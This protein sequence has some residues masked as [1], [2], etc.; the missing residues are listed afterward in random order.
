MPSTKSPKLSQEP[1]SGWCA[2]YSGQT[3]LG[4]LLSRGRAGA[5]AFDRNDRSLGVFPDLKSAAAA[6]SAAGTSS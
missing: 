1:P 5:E 2:L 6:V 4:H 3:C